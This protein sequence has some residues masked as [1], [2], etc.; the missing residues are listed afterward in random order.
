VSL[1]RCTSGSR[2][3]AGPSDAAEDAP[4]VDDGSSGLVP[5]DA[6][7]ALPPRHVVRTYAPTYHAVYSEILAPVCGTEFCHGGASDYLELWSEDKGYTS[8][9]GAPAQGPLCAATG[10][11][12]VDPGL[13]DAS[14]VYLKITHPPC[15]NKMPLSYGCIGLLDPGDSEQIR[16]WIAC[17]ALDGDAG[18]L[19]DAAAPDVTADGPGGDALSE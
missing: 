8:L 7:C 16:Q 6:T 15:G 10:L 12:R 2:E 5:F 3:S 4:L 9:V 17:G 18:C 1:A 13:P 19:G 14:L 11:K